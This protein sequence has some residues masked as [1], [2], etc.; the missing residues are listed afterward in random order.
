MMQFVLLLLIAVI[1]ALFWFLFIIKFDIQK[2][3][4]PKVLLTSAVL[5][6]IGALLV[7]LLGTPYQLGDIHVEDAHSFNESLAIGFFK[8]ALPSEVVKWLL[9]LGLLSINKFYDEYI[10]GAVYSVCLAMGFAGVWG[11][12]FL[13]D[14]VAGS[15]LT[16]LEISAI[17]IFVLIPLHF[18]AGILMGYFISLARKGRKFRNHALALFIPILVE[19]FL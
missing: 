4:P 19:G 9:L 17:T 3:E 5:G 15:F 13:S 2:P 14:Y 1:P 7:V 6:G 10:D 16:F 11:A 8:L 12:W 18:I